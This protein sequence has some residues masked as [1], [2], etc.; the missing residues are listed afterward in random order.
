MI[1]VACRRACLIST[2]TLASASFSSARARSAA[3]SPSATFFWRSSMAP[4]SWG[5]MNLVV[6]QTRI[7]KE[8]IWPRKV[9]LISMISPKTPNAGVLTVAVAGYAT[10]TKT[11]ACLAARG[12][13]QH[14]DQRIRESEQQ[15]DRQAD[16]ERHVDEAGEQEH[17]TLEQRNQLRLTGGRLEELRAHDGDTE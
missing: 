15:G 1:S 4:L 3:A 6:N 9:M 5:Q 10:A 12:G 14:V 11:N 2:A 17:T 7:A 13:A 16:D 8:I